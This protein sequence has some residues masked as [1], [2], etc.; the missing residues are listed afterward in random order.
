[1]SK[2]ILLMYISEVSGHHSASNAVENAIKT[3][4]PETEVLNINAFNY[5]NPIWERI[6]NRA[7]M[8]VVKNTPEIW[9]YLYDNPKVLRRTRKLRE[10][11]HRANTEKLKILFDEF[12]P[13]AVACTQAY[14]CGMVADYK[15]TFN[16]N[17]PLVGILTDYAPHS[18]WIYD[19]VDAYV[20]P[21]HETGLKLMRD[22]VLE[23]KIKSLGVPI[24]Q[25]FNTPL[26]KNL[27]NRELDLS[28]DVPKILMMGGGQGLGSIKKYLAALDKIKT[29]FYILVVTGTNT[30]LY[31]WIKTHKFKKVIMPFGYISFV[32]K[33][34]EI[35]SII[36]TKPGGVTTAEALSKT[37]PMLIVNPL[38]GQEAM[39]TKFLLKEGIALK[40]EDDRSLAELIDWLLNNTGK[41]KQISQK[42]RFYA[43]PD[44]AVKTAE[45]ILNLAQ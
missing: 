15:K 16:L 45:L 10:L 38:P 3:L 28:P 8:S 12:N 39:N 37:L 7:Y 26:D 25:K 13:D 22:G 29:D 6:I 21:S 18:Y 23:E 9:D 42:V 36:V 24:N 14:P 11:I 31:N 34:M 17:L 20:V 35:S 1:M 33:L 5:T 27:I 2:K 32:D 19:N 40:A 43:K 4:D 44:A 41:L 30:K